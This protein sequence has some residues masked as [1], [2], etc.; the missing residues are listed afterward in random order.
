M[1]GRKKDGCL[2][3]GQ[4]EALEKGFAGPFDKAGYPIYAPMTFDTGIV[5]T[6][7]GYLPTGA[8][9]PFGPPPSPA[10]ASISTRAST[11]S[12]RMRP[13]G[14]PTPTTG[15]ISTPSSIAAAR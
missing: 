7:M 11:R 9:G 12:G 2:S 15:S 1:L 4:V 5:A 8:P 6:P 3:A 13:D 10:T 14:G